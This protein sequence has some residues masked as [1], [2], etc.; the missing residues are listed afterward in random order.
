MQGKDG[1]QYSLIS[2]HNKQM[3]NFIELAS[4]TNYLAMFLVNLLT[5]IKNSA[6]KKLRDKQCW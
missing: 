6:A 3:I 5:G 4:M 2:A 1:G